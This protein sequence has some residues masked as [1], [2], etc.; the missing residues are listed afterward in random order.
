MLTE[1]A[2]ADMAT[3]VYIEPD[4]LAVYGKGLSEYEKS[5]NMPEPWPGGWWRLSDLIA[6][7][8]TSTYSIIKTAAEHKEDILK[9]RNDLCRKEVKKGL[10]EAPFY[11]IIP[12]EQHDPGEMV[13]L[14]NLLMEHGVNIFEN[15]YL[16]TI[17]DDIYT[18]PGRPGSPAGSAFPCFYQRGAGE[19]GLS[20]QA[21]Y[22][23]WRDH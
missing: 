2:S 16:T 12:K 10:T 18:S 21:L 23:E 11:Y 22:T 8:K 7:E 20:P 5:I 6:Y 15:T 17:V 1:G 9:F 4:E 3:P 14:V 19:T 13:R